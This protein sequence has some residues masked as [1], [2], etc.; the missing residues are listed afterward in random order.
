LTT[1]L[2]LVVARLLHLLHQLTHSSHRLTVVWT[3]PLLRVDDEGWDVDVAQVP[4]Y[5]D[6]LE[7]LREL[8]DVTIQVIGNRSAG[9]IEAPGAG[10]EKPKKGGGR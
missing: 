4:L 7:A 9:Q 8:A 5:L 6:E 2:V 1:L 3:M 10:P